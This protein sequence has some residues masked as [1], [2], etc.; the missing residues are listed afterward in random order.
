VARDLQRVLRRL[1]YGVPSVAVSGRMAL[2]QVARTR[3]DLVLMDTVL[4]G[5]LDGIQTTEL[6]SAECDVPVIY[7]TAHS[8]RYTFAR[9]RLTKPSGYILKPFNEQ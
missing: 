9:A 4:K 5:D 2:K 1:G 3:P 8:D 6:L 7:L